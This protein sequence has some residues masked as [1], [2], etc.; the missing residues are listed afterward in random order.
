MGEAYI[1]RL[2]HRFGDGP[3]LITDKLPGNF[4]FIGLIHLILP[5]AKIIH[6]QRDPLDT[7]L[8]IYNTLFAQLH[9]YAYDMR[10]L[11]Q[12]YQ[13]YS[14]LMKHWDQV[15]PGKIFHQRYEDLVG[16][17]EKS[18]RKVLD[19]CNLP[20][21]EKCLEFYKSD[22]RVRTASSQQVREQLHARSIG[23][24]RN[25]EKHLGEWKTMLGRQ[26]VRFS[27]VSTELIR[28]AEIQFKAAHDAQRCRQTARRRKP[29]ISRC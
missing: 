26:S 14:G 17:P 22:R 18:V 2:R 23:R 21:D 13:L 12:F 19:Y 1:T 20:F 10:E 24:W 4:L 7:C 11:G 25:Y 9:Y 8:S 28:Q 29:S 6:M 16:D 3:R 15:L 27:I 5:K